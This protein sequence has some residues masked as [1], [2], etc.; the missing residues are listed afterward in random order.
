VRQVLNM[1]PEILDDTNVGSFVF[2]DTGY[3][4]NTI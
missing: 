4:C 3:R 1:K 2:L